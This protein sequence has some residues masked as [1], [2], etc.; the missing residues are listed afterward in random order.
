M[1]SFINSLIIVFT[2]LVLMA[3][4]HAAP[5][6][7]APLP[8]A[9]QEALN[10]GIIAAKVPDYLLAIRYF[11][12]AR[13][14]APQAPVIYLNLGLAESRIPSRELRAIAWF[15][16]YLA[17]YPDAPNAAAVNEHI[18]VLKVKSQSNTSRLIKTVQEVA[19]QIP[20]DPG[21]SQVELVVLLAKAGDMRAA[22]GVAD[23]IISDIRKTQA[24]RGIATVRANAGDIAGAQ[25]AVD[26]MRESNDKS[27]AQ[28]SIAAAQAKGG[29]FEGAQKTAD[30]IQNAG[31]KK[32]AQMDIVFAQ[33][34]SGDIAGA[35]KAAGLIQDASYDDKK[36]MQYVIAGAQATAGDIAG[37]LRAA[38]LIQDADKKRWAQMIIV[39]AQATAGDIA[40]ALKTA[41]LVLG[42][43]TNG[44]SKNNAW[45]S[46]SVVQ[47]KGGDIAGAQKTADLIEKAVDKGTAQ[48]AIA[49]AQ[50]KAGDIAGADKTLAS[51][52]KT[53]ELL[54]DDREAFY[55]KILIPR[56]ITRTKAYIT[57]A[58]NSTRQSTAYTQSP[59]QP[60]DTVYK[61]LR[62]LD[63]DL[64]FTDCP[65]N[66]EPFLDLAGYLKSLPP[67][68]NPQRAFD[69]LHKTAETI[70][71]AQN[72]IT[73]MLR[74][75]AKR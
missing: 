70:V 2:F 42:E 59:I 22:L 3:S 40:G 66:T 62:E 33:A 35:Q 60:V 64:K 39:S 23:K 50:I 20:G 73:G 41:D 51:V 43:S 46:I 31:Y 7:P 56:W 71:K 5:S 36:T 67:S 13:K 49:E 58:R 63:N 48:R 15:G 21:H 26:L 74:Q 68:D 12:E 9:S 69:S 16:A 17:A 1:K 18:S 57:I 54:D 34:K 52:Q 37:A 30:L 45:A 24:H 47:A 32:E 29:D 27:N 75:L 65:L 6:E 19:S 25:M 53:A 44:A 14:L 72:V 10:K 11:E 55:K 38:D 4:A 28:R 61:W 8:P